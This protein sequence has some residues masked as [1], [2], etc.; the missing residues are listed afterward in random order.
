MEPSDGLRTLRIVPPP[1][2]LEDRPV[3]ELS[4]FEL[5][6]VVNKLKQDLASR[7]SQPGPDIKPEDSA[8]EVIEDDDVAIVEHPGRKRRRGQNKEVFQLD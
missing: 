7:P 8:V 3:E 4:H 6:E 1:I 2:S 5:R